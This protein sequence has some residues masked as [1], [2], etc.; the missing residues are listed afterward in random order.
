[1]SNENNQKTLLR[2]TV[3]PFINID[4]NSLS[5]S[6]IGKKT[7]YGDIAVINIFQN[8]YKISQLF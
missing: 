1:M 8:I 6:Y 7:N 3:S 4:S 2:P 5:A